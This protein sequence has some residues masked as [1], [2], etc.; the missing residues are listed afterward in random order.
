MATAGRPRR[1]VKSGHSLEGH[2]HHAQ[3]SSPSEV[4]SCNYNALPIAQRPWSWC[5]G[6]GQGLVD[7]PSRCRANAGW[8]RPPILKPARLTFGSNRYR[9]RPRPTA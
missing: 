9:W 1:L 3:P 8:N 6:H 2:A 5:R 4:Q 7:A